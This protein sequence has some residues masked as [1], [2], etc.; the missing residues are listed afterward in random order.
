[1]PTARL[2]LGALAIALCA[3]ACGSPAPA[4]GGWP[5]GPAGSASASPPSDAQPPITAKV[6]WHQD[7][8]SEILDCHYLKAPNDA[9]AEIARIKA[10]FPAGS[11]HV[12]VYHASV[13]VP[14]HVEPCTNID[15]TTW[16]L[17]VGVQTQPIDWQL[18]AGV[19]VPLAPHEQLMVQVHWLNTTAQPIDRE[20]DLAFYPTTQSTAHLGVVF[21]VSKDVYMVPGQSKSVGGWCPIEAG[22]NVAAVMGHFHGRGRHYSVDLRKSG[23]PSGKVIYSAADEQTFEF[24]RFDAPPVPAPGEGL[25]YQCDYQNTTN[26]VIT[27][28]ANTRTQEHCNMAA[29]YYPASA[30]L[31]HLYLGGE[32]A[33]A[34]LQPST[35]I[36][37][38][39]A[40][41]HVQLKEQ[42]GPEGVDVILQPP[43]GAPL[44]LPPLARVAP[45]AWGA[46]FAL[47][48]TA[49]GQTSLALTTGAGD[50]TLPV[51]IVGGP[52]SA[53]LALSEVYLGPSASSPG[54]AQWIEIANVGSA[55]VD[56]SGYSIAAGGAAYGSVRASL[57]AFVLPPD[58]CLVVGGPQGLPPSNPGAGVFTVAESFTPS[59]PTGAAPAS[60]IAL[61]NV[62][63]A[64]PLPPGA[65]PLDAVVYGT[66]NSTGLLGPDGQPAAAV[67]SP[68]PGASLERTAGWHT[69]TTPT[70]GIC[71][72]SDAP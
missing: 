11:H 72:V 50:T 49:A 22:V 41:G 21:G 56:L 43:A 1:M 69:Q 61:F 28:G 53:G 51:S 60:G 66:S 65:V 19:T 58:G 24:Q 9:A 6:A 27:W 30:P 45:W 37:G 17:V 38:R 68:A 32:V 48:G 15:W 39:S 54:D 63:L 23:E 62:P 2:L 34:A 3:G 14:D 67:S 33:T 59:L 25:A 40:Q 52:G 20:I 70:P 71:R 7:A 35:L 47:E 5:G 10:D 8:Q 26:G 42:A 16:S 55:P 57:G 46:D 64:Q 29:Y 18:P 44:T 31:S 36:A 13:D 12:H 4:G